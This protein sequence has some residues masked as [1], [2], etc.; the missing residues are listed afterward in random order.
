MSTNVNTSCQPSL[1]PNIED[2]QR[3]I[4]SIS[5][6]STHLPSYQ[7]LYPRLDTISSL[8]EMAWH[9]DMHPQ[10]SAPAQRD[11]L[12]CAPLP[13][14][15]SYLQAT[16]I[17]PRSD[18]KAQDLTIYR[19]ENIIPPKKE[20]ITSFPEMIPHLRALEQAMK[21]TVTI[22]PFA[23]PQ[24]LAKL[25]QTLVEE[26]LKRGS[27]SGKIDA[28]FA[29]SDKS[30]IDTLNALDLR[31]E[32]I[33][34]TKID[35][36][37]KLLIEVCLR[38]LCAHIIIDQLQHHHIHDDVGNLIL[39]PN[40]YS[41]MRNLH[42]FVT[43][44]ETFFPTL[45][46]SEAFCTPLTDPF[47]KSSMAAFHTNTKDPLTDA[48]TQLMTNE[49]RL[50]NQTIRYGLQHLPPYDASIL[51]S[52]I[53][54]QAKKSSFENIREDL[55][56]KVNKD[57][58]FHAFA[59]ALKKL[60]FIGSSNEG[61]VALYFKEYTEKY[62]PSLDTQLVI[63]HHI[64][65]TTD[66]E[67]LKQIWAQK[68]KEQLVS[69]IAGRYNKSAEQGKLPADWLIEFTKIQNH[70]HI[71][72]DGL[73]EL[74]SPLATHILMLAQKSWEAEEIRSCK[75][76][77]LQTKIDYVEK[78][79]KTT[80]GTAIQSTQKADRENGKA[81]L[82]NVVRQLLCKQ[83][84]SLI[85]EPSIPSYLEHYEGQGYLPRDV[86][87]HAKAL[88][89][90][91][92]QNGLIPLKDDIL[93]MELSLLFGDASRAK[94]LLLYCQAQKKS[95]MLDPTILARKESTLKWAIE[96][97]SKKEA[98]S[99]AS[100]PIPTE[101]KGVQT[102]FTTEED[103][104]V[105]VESSSEIALAKAQLK[106]KESIQQIEILRGKGHDGQIHSAWVDYL[107]ALRSHVIAYID[108]NPRQEVLSYG[109]IQLIE[110]AKE[111]HDQLLGLSELL[112]SIIKREAFGT[113]SMGVFSVQDFVD[114]TDVTQFV[115][116][117]THIE[118]TKKCFDDL[119]SEE[120]TLVGH[121]FSGKMLTNES[122]QTIGYDVSEH[123]TI[124]KLWAEVKHLSTSA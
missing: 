118:H 57:Q 89:R 90:L 99:L 81:I 21:K 13:S 50:L 123:S 85:I 56:S 80:L 112:P 113:I 38:R 41:W 124:A 92:T 12:P 8:E 4:D 18:I 53:A 116:S 82:E 97:L 25:A 71:N 23:P 39:H 28:A 86:Q 107:K 58:D 5:I 1:Y 55:F 16:A 51:S 26:C 6:R 34:S 43:R 52:S 94:N 42:I 69:Y 87:D 120:D 83:M 106:L 44:N 77:S 60:T 105:I 70:F 117:R 62:K 49:Y 54:L 59:I 35:A 122:G 72:A 73:N 114:T 93:K 74:F 103:D 29:S 17:P 9:P 78:V 67:G 79:L 33:F 95:R 96:V 64:L 68:L 46:V 10:P 84:F 65:E 45:N 91:Q 27:E 48:T 111:D 108:L 115:K 22:N 119:K 110:D 66:V 15:P 109:E 3:E 63:C 40:S 47:M 11:L 121:G 14:T 76:L 32:Q 100:I 88:E 7:E 31:I 37:N 36:E 19:I 101:S 61:N 98:S 102:D 20:G 75:T 30:L 2:L 104:F 24:Q